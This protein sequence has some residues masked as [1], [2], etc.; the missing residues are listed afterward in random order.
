MSHVFSLPKTPPSVS[1]ILNVYK[2]SE[3]LQA[4]LGAIAAQTLPVSETLIWENGE[5]ISAK[6]FEALRARSDSNLGV[7]ARFAFALNSN[8]E[9]VWIID[10]DAIPGPGWLESAIRTHKRTGGL[11]G[12]RGLRFRTKSSYTLYEEFGPNSPNDQVEE[13]DIVGHN[14]VFPREWLGVF[15][16][17]IGSRFHNIRAGEDIHLSYATQK[18]LGVGTFVPP[19]PA[20]NRTIWGEQ[21]AAEAHF[22]R[23]EHAI[24]RSMES[25]KKFEDAYAHYIRRGFQPMCSRSEI[26]TERTKDRVLGAAVR[27]NPVLAHKVAK[28]MRL[29]K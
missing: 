25:M 7:W 1:V 11:V 21:P 28:F 16:A 23:D 19:H 18:H 29:T 8:S 9:F 12:S 3:N 26:L 15:W 14:W 2:R 13:V 24:S 10:D 4:Q 6:P 17:E 5:E 20:N 22:G 27:F